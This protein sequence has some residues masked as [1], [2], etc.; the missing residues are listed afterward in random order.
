MRP[1]RENS[2]RIVNQYVLQQT[3]E[4][5]SHE[6]VLIL[7]DAWDEKT[8]SYT[9]KRL[10]VKEHTVRVTRANE[11][12][13]KV[14]RA[15]GVEKI[16]KVHYRRFM[17]DLLESIDAKGSD[18]VP[19]VAGELPRT[20]GFCGRVP[21]I[22]WLEAA[23][24]EAKCISLVGPSGIGKTALVAKVLSDFNGNFSRCLWREV[25]YQPTEEELIED[26]LYYLKDVEIETRGDPFKQLVSFLNDNRYIIVLDGIEEASVYQYEKL[27]KRLVR[28]AHGSCIVLTSRIPIPGLR[29]LEEQGYPI[30]NYKVH[31][32]KGKDAYALL[33]KL[34]LPQNE[35]WESLVSVYT[36]NPK[37]LSTV[38]L[39]IKEHYGGDILNFIENGTT[40]PISLFDKNFPSKVANLTPLDHSILDFVSRKDCST[41]EIITSMDP[42]RY[43]IFE[44]LMK[45]LDMCLI[46]VDESTNL[47]HVPPVMS[48]YFKDLVTT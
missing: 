9:A 36:G 8:Y 48:K 46:E 40:L 43:L 28:D 30:Y 13:K 37:I 20:D 25:S 34:G 12:L 22:A 2:I 38:S 44:S 45:L 35:L 5:L 31:G 1:T 19:V 42:A 4:P 23:L 26:L 27:L 39:M 18:P 17:V 24:T 15:C 47:Y 33:E 7:E 6:E 21:E 11:L 14:A 32:L 29:D 16:E 3:Q 41:D 10:G